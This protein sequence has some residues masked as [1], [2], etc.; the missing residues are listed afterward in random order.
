MEHR[1]AG[2]SASRNVSVLISVGVCRASSL[3][4]RFWGVLE[5]HYCNQTHVPWSEGPQCVGDDVD[6]SRTWRQKPGGTNLAEEIFVDW[7][8]F[9]TA[10][11]FCC[12]LHALGNPLLCLWFSCVGVIRLGGGTELI[13]LGG[14]SPLSLL[15]AGFE[16][17]RSSNQVHLAVRARQMFSVI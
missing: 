10:R 7:C 4:P 8:G 2:I 9:K 3:V 1:G 6:E 14:S 5:P 17:I 12:Q 16:Q 11:K 13:R 15:L